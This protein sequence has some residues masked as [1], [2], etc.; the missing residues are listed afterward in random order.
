MIFG[1]LSDFIEAIYFPIALAVVDFLNV[2]FLFAGATAIAALVGAGN[3]SH[4]DTLKK[5]GLNSTQDC[6]LGQAGSAFLYFSFALAVGNLVYSI[7]GS[8]NSGS[9]GTPGR[10]STVPRTGIPTASQV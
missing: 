5:H 7:L 2:V 1:L 6:R 8:L 3:C 4:E 10:K 9:I